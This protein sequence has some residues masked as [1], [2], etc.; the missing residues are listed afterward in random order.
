MSNPIT[1]REI[2]K[3]NLKNPVLIDGFPGVGLVGTIVA[4]FLI[5]TLKLEQIG[6]IDSYKFPPISV[7]KDG[8]PHNPMRLYSGEQ[9]C[10]DGSCNQVIVLR[11][12]IVFGRQYGCD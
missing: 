8:E 9:I 6:V 10:N 3:H 4:N 2:A 12:A 7:V 5:N 11:R 1:I